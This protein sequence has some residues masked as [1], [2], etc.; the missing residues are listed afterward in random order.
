[1]SNWISLGGSFTNQPW[2][3][4]RWWLY[5]WQEPL[6]DLPCAVFAQSNS[7]KWLFS[8][9]SKGFEASWTSLLQSCSL[10][11]E[12]VLL[13]AVFCHLSEKWQLMRLNW[14][15]EPVTFS[16]NTLSPETKLPLS[17][18]CVGRKFSHYLTMGVGWFLILWPDDLHKVTVLSIWTT[19]SCS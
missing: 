17:W 5:P 19:K 10:I 9:L 18:Q 15:T 16:L 12:A 1:M 7:M 14:K 13:F 2:Q 6:L 3:L 8:M 4:T 11:P